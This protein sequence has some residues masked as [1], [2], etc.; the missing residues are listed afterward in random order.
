MR[1]QGS[2]LAVLSAREPMRY[3]CGW[4]EEG[5]E[6]LVALF[7]PARGAPALVV[8]AMSGQQAAANPAGILDV[9]LWRDGTGWTPVVQSLLAEFGIEEGMTVLVDEGL[10]AIHLLA[11][12]SMMPC[13][14]GL[15]GDL[16]WALRKTKSA[17]EIAALERAAMMI[18]VVVDEVISALREGMTERQA[19][20]VTLEAIERQGSRPA[21]PP[22]VCFGENGAMPHHEAD[23]TPLRRGDVA[24]IDI[25]CAAGDYLSDITRT[26]A[27]GEP[28]DPDARRVYETVY[29]AHIAA[30]MAAAAP[31][32]T[33]EQVDAAARGVIEAAGWGPEFVHRT[34]HGIGMSPH[35]PPYIVAGE[36]QRLLPGTTFSIEPGIYLPGRFGV[37]IENIV[38]VTDSGCRSLNAEPASSL[39]IIGI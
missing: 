39:L 17:E 3:L 7:V 14:Y 22:L 8:P 21:F 26:V 6:R 9:R 19:V 12:Q 35:E 34:G 15:A 11:L 1:R 29:A 33:G 23:D 13:V 10:P 37:R 20:R 27:F 25:G 16:L 32:A 38:A 36:R 28:A 5:H 31:D 30:R 4:W 18:D 2:H 24:I